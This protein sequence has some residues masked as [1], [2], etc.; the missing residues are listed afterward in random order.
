MAMFSIHLTH[1]NVY[2]SESYYDITPEDIQELEK[3]DKINDLKETLAKTNKAYNED[4]AFKE[5]MRN[6]KSLTNDDFEKSTTSPE[7]NVSK[8]ERT[9]TSSNDNSS[10]SYTENQELI[11]QYKNTE[12]L[13]SRFSKKGDKNQE[14]NKASTLTYSLKDR[15]LLHYDTPRYLCEKG[16]KIVVNIK[17][18]SQ[19][20]VT[21]A[22]INNTSTSTNECLISHALEYAQSVLFDTSTTPSQIGSITF[23]FKSKH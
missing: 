19:G 13:L 4:E 12:S 2:N 6:F 21:E 10:N 7:Q 22:Y 18:N 20:K 17:V 3:L 1:Q 8:S 5:A 9:V 15:Q 16:G 11:E 23:Y 14:G